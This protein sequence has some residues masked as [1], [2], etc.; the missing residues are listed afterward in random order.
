MKTDEEILKRWTDVVDYTSKQIP[1]LPEDKR[2]SMA[3]ACEDW[4]SKYMIQ[5]E[6]GFTSNAT[7]LKYTIPQLRRSENNLQI[8]DDIVIDGRK[9]MLIAHGE[10]YEYKGIMAIPYD[11]ER[12]NCHFDDIYVQEEKNT[13]SQMWH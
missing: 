9:C 12:G 7:F 1:P 2:M 3:K 4:E 8:L 11:T 13:W 5:D 6:K 10:L